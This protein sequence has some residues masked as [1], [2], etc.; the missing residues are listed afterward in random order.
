MH[1]LEMRY[2]ETLNALSKVWGDAIPEYAG[3]AKKRLIHAWLAATSG[4]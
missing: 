4:S 1:N 2:R 3:Y